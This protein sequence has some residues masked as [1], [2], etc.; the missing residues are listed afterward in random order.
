[1]QRQNVFLSLSFLTWV[2]KNTWVGGLLKENEWHTKK[3]IEEQDK[4][5][6]T[7]EERERETENKT[8][9][10]ILRLGRRWTWFE[11]QLKTSFFSRKKKA[12]RKRFWE[13]T[14][15]DPMLLLLFQGC[16][17]H[18]NEMAP[19]AS[20]S[21]WL[22]VVKERRWWEGT[23]SGLLMHHLFFLLHTWKR[24]HMHTW[25]I[26]SLSCKWQTVR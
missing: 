11:L 4:E 15:R 12:G 21:F 2:S 10:R 8:R 24:I 20:E 25:R 26:Y 6:E 23:S 13:M 22:L 17:V 9:R 14:A 18:R 7:K 19:W 5:W 16:Q 1:M 3:V